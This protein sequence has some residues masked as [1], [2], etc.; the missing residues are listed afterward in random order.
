MENTILL[1]LLLSP[2][3]IG[4]AVNKLLTGDTSTEPINQ[5]IMSYFLYSASALAITELIFGKPLSSILAG[6]KMTVYDCFYPLAAAALISAL[7][8]IVLRDKIVTPAINAVMRLLGRNE[9]ALSNLLLYNMLADG[10]GHIIE[11]YS[12]ADNK[13]LAQGMV[14]EVSK[15]EKAIKLSPLPAWV[16][17][18]DVK[19]YEV[20]RLLLIKEELLV[21]EYAFEYTG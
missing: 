14:N 8:E 20:Q 21:I 1:I 4:I 19:R 13:L 11:I 10:R 3:F 12:T 18:N 16:N 5:N 15:D 6:A 17:D 9:I 7:W 2:G